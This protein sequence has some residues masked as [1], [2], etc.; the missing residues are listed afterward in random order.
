MAVE[1]F[2][3]Y[4]EIDEDGDLTVTATKIDVSTMRRDA[5]S[6]VRVDKGA[7]TIGEFF[8]YITVHVGTYNTNASCGV[9]AVSADPS[10]TIEQMSDNDDGICVELRGTQFFVTDYTNNNFDSYIHNSTNTT[11]YLTVRRYNAGVMV[12]FYS[13]SDR[14]TL[15]DTLHIN[16]GVNTYQYLY[17]LVSRE[18][19][20]FTSDSV[21]CYTENL[22]T[23]PFVTPDVTVQ[24]ILND[25]VSLY[26]LT[27][28]NTVA[29]DLDGFASLY[30]LT[31]DVS[32]TKELDGLVTIYVLTSD[33][34]ATDTL[35]PSSLY[36][37]TA[38]NEAVNNLF[39]RFHFHSIFCPLWNFLFL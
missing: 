29:V 18:G 12:R 16:S 38:D 9:W 22:D 27:A 11:Y 14:D 28:D 5:L 25:A 32:I 26:T 24:D 21:T 7:G 34:S 23:S 1:D 30:I 19:S 20:T 10:N 31:F 17:G 15:L 4:T 2:T 3:T 13:D 36:V 37:L 35:S 8:H 39:I 6:Y 33:V